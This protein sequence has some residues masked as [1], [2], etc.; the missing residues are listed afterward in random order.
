MDSLVYVYVCAVYIHGK[1]STL[2]F[3]TR[4]NCTEMSHIVLYT[5]CPVQVFAKSECFTFPQKSKCLGPSFQKV[6]VSPSPSF[7][8]VNVS[9]SPTP[10]EY[11]RKVNVSPS[12]SFFVEGK[13]NARGIFTSGE[14]WA[15]LHES[16]CIWYIGHQF[17]DRRHLWLLS[18]ISAWRWSCWWSAK[19]TMNTCSMVPGESLV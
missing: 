17:V 18:L 6:N 5:L 3:T 9:L 12:P 19:G 10:V 14:L 2:Q 7:R 13:E 1:Y 4:P 16:T 8:K 15:S 11:F